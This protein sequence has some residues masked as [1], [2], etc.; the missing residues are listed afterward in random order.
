MSA[1]VELT[2][3]VGDI[4]ARLDMS[5]GPGADAL[6]RHYIDPTMQE[7]DRVIVDAFGSNRKPFNAKNYPATVAYT[8]DTAAQAVVFKLG[9][10]GFWVF[11]QYGTKPHVIAPKKMK[12]L[13]AAGVGHPWRGPVNHPGTGDKGTAGKKGKRAIDNAYRAIHSRRHERVTAAVDEVFTNG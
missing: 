10:T 7:L 4:A 8:I 1:L 2:A 5:T 11:G 3:R 9:P 12:R 13:N 6:K